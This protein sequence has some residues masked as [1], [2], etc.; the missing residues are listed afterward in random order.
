MD[1]NSQKNKMYSVLVAGDIDMSLYDFNRKVEPYILYQ[2]DKRKE[3]RE[4]AI[5]FY[6]QYLNNL[7]NDDLNLFLKTFLSSKIEDIQEMSDEEYF[8]SVTKGLKYDEKTGDA[9]SDFNPMGKYKILMEPTTEDTV[10]LKGNRF[11]CKV[12]ELPERIEDAEIIKK[13]S[14]YWEDKIMTSSSLKEDYLNA[15]ENK[16]TYISV[17]TEPLFFNAFVSKETGWLEQ[18]DENQIQWVLNFRK[19][20]IEGLPDNTILKVY[21][22]TR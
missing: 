5:E 21:K 9:I 18:C 7:Q 13:Y 1:S 19:R 2:Y 20:F 11:Q 10:P 16:E 14:D 4:T 6:K 8:E 12:S 17:M 22:F 3:I 15:Y